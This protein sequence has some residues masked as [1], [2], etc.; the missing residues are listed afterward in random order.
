[1]NQ[2]G[3]QQQK[4]GQVEGALIQEGQPLPLD[5]LHFQ[6]LGED[7]KPQVLNMNNP[8]PHIKICRQRHSTAHHDELLL[9][10]LNTR[11]VCGEC[12]R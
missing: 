10:I 7:N 1:M 4:Q 6:I 5:Q 11:C 9:R 2:E 12:R 3:Q 8:L